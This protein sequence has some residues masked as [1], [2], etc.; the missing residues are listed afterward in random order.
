MGRKDKKVE[1]VVGVNAPINEVEEPE[2]TR[3]D[4]VGGSSDENDRNSSQYLDSSDEVKYYS[5]SDIEYGETALRRRSTLVRNGF[6]KPSMSE[7][8]NCQVCNCEG[9]RGGNEKE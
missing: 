5:D 1:E 4:E 9:L 2:K 3:D 8:Y 7:M 6:F